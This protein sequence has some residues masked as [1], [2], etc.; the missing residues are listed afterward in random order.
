[1]GDVIGRFEVAIDLDSLLTPIEASSKAPQSTE[2]T[3][4]A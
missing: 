4:S 1:V 3:V 2:Q